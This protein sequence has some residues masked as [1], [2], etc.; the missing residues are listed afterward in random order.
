[1]TYEALEP[2]IERQ[3]VWFQVVE[4]VLTAAQSLDIED[5][6]TQQ[7]IILAKYYIVDVLAA[8]GNN[9]EV[10]L[11][12]GTGS[13][14]L[15]Y[16]LVALVCLMIASKVQSVEAY[17]R[18]T[19]VRKQILSLQSELPH[20]PDGRFVLKVRNQ[21]QVACTRLARLERDIFACLGFRVN[22]PTPAEFITVYMQVLE[23]KVSKID[24]DTIQ[25]LRG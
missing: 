14:F 18:V 22:V 15:D 12:D 6:T 25:L 10:E 23:T 1:M 2:L 7:A 3:D 9:E 20:Q 21:Q 24:P 11:G 16:A 8:G 13:D 17:L 19:D 5:Q 4:L